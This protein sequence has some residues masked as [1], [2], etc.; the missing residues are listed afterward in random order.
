MYNQIDS[1]KRKSMV[2]IFIFLVLITVIGYILS[3]VLNYG[4][5]PLVIAALISTV[6]VGI[7]Y[8]AGD[9]IALVSAGAKSISKDENPYVYRIVENLCITAGLPTPK[10]YIINDPAPN[11]FAA[12][13]NPEHSSIAITTGLIQIMEN[14]ELEGVIAHELSHV[15]NY[16]V[17]LA[18]LVVVLVGALSIFADMFT[19]S[20]LFGG[21]RRNNNNGNG[22]GILAIIGIVLIILSPI[23]GQLIQ[24]AISRKRE[25]LADASGA[26]MTRYPE[27][28]ARALE[29]IGQYKQPMQRFSNA[30]A[31]LFF[32][33]PNFS[34][35]KLLGSLFS[36][37]PPIEQRVKAL[38]GMI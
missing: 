16:D 7:S 2:L 11:A 33:N 8:F 17:R 36:T 29:K 32:A 26:L 9:K 31:H 37:H 30:T 13:R 21:R 4:Y 20:L 5:S 18:T 14:E 28:L 38:R 12:G 34:S 22:N 3:R 25:F 23:I 24:L 27:A 15:K 35:K 1:N 6:M 19:R 10:I